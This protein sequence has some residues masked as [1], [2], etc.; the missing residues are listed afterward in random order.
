VKASCNFGGLGLAPIVGG[1]H[2][3]FAEVARAEGKSGVP[4]GKGKEVQAFESLG[5]TQHASEV[6]FGF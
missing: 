4:L 1:H 3:S 5:K 6:G 2:R